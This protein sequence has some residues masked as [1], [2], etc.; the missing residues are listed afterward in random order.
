VRSVQHMNKVQQHNFL[1]ICKNKVYF[2]FLLKVSNFYLYLANTLAFGLLLSSCTWPKA[3]RRSAS[4]LSRRWDISG[5][6]GQTSLGHRSDRSTCCQSSSYWLAP[7]A[8]KPLLQPWGYPPVACP[9][10]LFQV[11]AHQ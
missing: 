4:P 9:T 8:L 10:P 11:F 5:G 7:R 3:P 6:T 2:N 1:E